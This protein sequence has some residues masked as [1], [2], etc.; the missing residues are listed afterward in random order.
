VLNIFHVPAALLLACL[1]GLLDIMPILGFLIAAGVAFLVAFSVS[2][3]TAF[4]V[5]GL[6]VVYHLLEAYVIMPKVYGKNLRL[7]T[8]T[9]LLALLAGSILAGVA[10]ALIALPI[11][12]SYSVVE[13]IWLTPWLGEAVAEKHQDQEEK[14][15]GEK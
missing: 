7:S 9:V 13:A 14:E 8:L 4:S 15:F 2:V 11:V 5:L 3:V 12:A 1:A 10:G 6:Y